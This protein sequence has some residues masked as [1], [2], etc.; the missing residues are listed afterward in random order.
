M[1]VSARVDVH[2]VVFGRAGT[3]VDSETA[4]IVVCS[5]VAVC[6]DV[7]MMTGSHGFPLLGTQSS[8]GAGVDVGVG[9]GVDVDVK[10]VVGGTLVDTSSTMPVD[11][12]S[13]TSNA[14]V[15]GSVGVVGTSAIPVDSEPTVPTVVCSSVSACEDVVT[16]SHGFPLL[17]T[18]PPSGA[19]EDVDVDVEVNTVVGSATLVDTKSLPVDSETTGPTVVSSSVSN[20][21]VVGRSSI[22]VDSETTATVVGSSVSVCEVVPVVSA[23]SHGMS[24][25]GTQSSPEVEVTLVLVKTV[26][27][28]IVVG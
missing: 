23:W 12:C 11:S 14:R 6:E 9:V 4:A 20:A 19:G 25:L 28:S 21:M 2:A 3:L 15:L 7:V 16:G 22:P 5:S 10:G 13:S 27:A 26:V 1:V 24:L 18:Q 8:S 17:G